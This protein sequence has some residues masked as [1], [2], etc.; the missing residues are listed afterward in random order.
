MKVLRVLSEIVLAL[1]A[2]A[3]A[4]D[5]QDPTTD[6]IVIFTVEQNDKFLG[7]LT[8]G[9]FSEVV[10]KTTENFYLLA[11]TQKFKNTL[12]HRVIKDFMIQGGDIDGEGGYSIYGK[13]KGSLPDE[14]F[15]LKHD[16]I[17]RLAM[18]NSGP[19]SGSSQFYI[20][21]KVTKWLDGNY[22]VFGQLLDGFD[23]LTTVETTKTDKFD[24]PLDVVKISNVYTYKDGQLDTQLTEEEKQYGLEDTTKSV[25]EQQDTSEDTS[26]D[27]SGDTSGDTDEDTSEDTSKDS[28]EDT[29]DNT[30]KDTSEDT[31][32]DTKDSSE[33]TLDEVV[34]HEMT[35]DEKNKLYEKQRAET[36]PKY[37]AFY[38]LVPL[39]LFMALLVFITLKTRKNI[40]YAIRGPRYRRIQVHR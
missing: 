19:N 9:L 16:K 18:A 11:K 14:N 32:E 4:E 10:P 6:R 28:S 23:T 3:F 1:S 25:V 35:Q 27:T 36:Q 26:E 5:N 34:N 12:F 33:D 21:G 31:G 39:G 15:L 37:L 8:L 17:G 38:A 20:T 30:S 24:M 2:I 13:E 40:L 7:N 29:S 22:V